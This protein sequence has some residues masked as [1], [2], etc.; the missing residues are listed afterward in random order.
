MKGTSGIEGGNE[1]S[2]TKTGAGGQLSPRQKGG[3]SHM[4]GR[5]QAHAISETPS[6]WLT[7]FAYSGNPLR[8]HP[9]QLIAVNSGLHI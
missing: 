3:Q 9:T 4:H 7:L 2:G 5:H 8:L 1:V 6:T